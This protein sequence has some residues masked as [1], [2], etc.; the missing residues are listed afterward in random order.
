[1][2]YYL[3]LI[4]ILFFIFIILVIYSCIKISGEISKK[5]EESHEKRKEI[6]H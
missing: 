1:M 5:E 4:L 2:Q 3:L 6:Q